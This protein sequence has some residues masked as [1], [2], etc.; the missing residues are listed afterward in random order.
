M[1]SGFLWIYQDWVFSCLSWERK[2]DVVKSMNSFLFYFSENKVS[3]CHPMCHFR[4]IVYRL[5]YT[6]C[7]KLNWWLLLPSIIITLSSITWRWR[8][9][10]WEAG[11]W[12]SKQQIKVEEFEWKLSAHSRFSQLAWTSTQVLWTKCNCCKVLKRMQKRKIGPD[13]RKSCYFSTLWMESQLRDCAQNVA[14]Q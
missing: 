8:S 3:L 11:L 5:V 1:Q 2:K 9:F 13:L 14:K 7:K 4:G 10:Y 6:D 12:Q